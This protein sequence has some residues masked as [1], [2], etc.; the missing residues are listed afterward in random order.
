MGNSVKSK[1]KNLKLQ[2]LEIFIPPIYG[3]FER[4]DDSPVD[5]ELPYRAL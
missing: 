4:G 2:V 1:W 5:L 3:R